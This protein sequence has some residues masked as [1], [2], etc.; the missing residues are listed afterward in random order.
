MASL[1]L[2]ARGGAVGAGGAGRG[3][4]AVVAPTPSLAEFAAFRDGAVTGRRACG[5]PASLSASFRSPGLE[6][7]DRGITVRS[8]TNTLPGRVKKNIYKNNNLQVRVWS[9][10]NTLQL[11][12]WVKRGLIVTDSLVCNKHITRKGKKVVSKS[13]IVWS[14]TNTLQARV[15]DSLVRNKHITRKGH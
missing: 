13:L 3:R 5:G 4:E 15:T 6:V 10:T 7:T 2:D 1:A 9:A 12:G 14:A 8:A 11:Q